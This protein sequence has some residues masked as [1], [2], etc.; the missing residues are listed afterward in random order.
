MCIKYTCKVQLGTIYIVD[1]KRHKIIVI[2]ILCI[3][4]S[5]YYT[6]ILYM[7]FYFL[8]I[9]L[10]IIGCTFLEF[11]LFLIHYFYT[12]ICGSKRFCL[13]MYPVW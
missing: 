8:N 11:Y 7:Y 1:N 10:F 9:Y 12:S 13:V 3:H 4:T 6:S 5:L 2:Y